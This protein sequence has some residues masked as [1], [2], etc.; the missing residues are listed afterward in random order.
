MKTLQLNRFLAWSAIFVFTMLLFT[1]NVE[2]Q[3]GGKKDPKK[4]GGGELAI[5][6]GL[7]EFFVDDNS[8]RD[9][10]KAIYKRDATRLALRL[11]NTEQRL[12]KQT[13]IVP[14]ELVQAVYNAL[15]AVRT[16]DYG[17]I[18]TIASKYNVR[19]FPVPNVESIILVFE[20]DATWVEPLKQRAD[21]TAS[22]TINNIIRQYNLIM[23][24]MVYL[25]E[26][27]AGL[28]LRSREPIN[29]PALAMKFFTEEGI[30]SIEEVLPYGDGND[31]SIVRVP[32]QGWDLT[33][34]IKFGNCVNQCQKFHDW[35]FKVSESG[36][37]TYLGGSG[38]TI[39]PWITV[40]AETKKYPDVLKK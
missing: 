3:R 1:G 26:E 28:V 2:A 12:S 7:P 32:Q 23:T 20:H 21:T 18:D 22:L 10:L 6:K 4:T 19:S 13:I 39:P 33:Y 11:I 27:R 9:Y 8:M 5:M 40:S 15:I 31:I 38:H 34:S 35:K 36:E 17:A 37:V 29:V 14:E 16:S 24:R 25:D 30:G